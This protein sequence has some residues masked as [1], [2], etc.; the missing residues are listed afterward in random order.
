[1]N[2]LRAA[3]KRDPLPSRSSGSPG[4]ELCGHHQRATEHWKLGRTGPHTRKSDSTG[5]RQRSKLSV[6]GPRNRS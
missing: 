5:P 4:W 1:M 3:N 2:A 6:K